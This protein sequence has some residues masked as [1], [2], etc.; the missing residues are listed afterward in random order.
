METE[1]HKHFI[2]HIDRL[3][4]LQTE[5]KSRVS[6]SQGIGKTS[7][8]MYYVLKCR[9]EKDTS[10]HYVDMNMIQDCDKDLSQ[11]SKYAKSFSKDD[12]L[13]IDHVTVQNEFCVDRLEEILV[14]LHKCKFQLILVEAGFTSSTAGRLLL[15]NRNL[16]LSE[17]EFS[18][19]WVESLK[20]V[21]E[22]KVIL[23]QGKEVYKLY[24]KDFI[25]TPKLL[26][27]VLL[28]M[29]GTT[30]KPEETITF[31]E[32]MLQEEIRN[33][34]IVREDNKM[35]KFILYTS[36][37]VHLI[38]NYGCCIFRIDQIGSVTVAIN[39]FEMQY[40]KVTKEDLATD[41]TFQMLG[42]TE[43]QSYVRLTFLIPRLAK[44]WQ[45]KLP[46]K[47]D[48]VIESSEHLKC[49]NS[50]RVLFQAGG[51]HK[52]IVNL[53]VRYQ[54]DVKLLINDGELMENKESNYQP[55]EAS[56]KILQKEPN[57]Q[58]ASDCEFLFPGLEVFANMKEVSK[59]V[60]HEKKIE[61]CAIML[62]ERMKSNP[63]LMYP[64]VSNVLGIDYFAYIPNYQGSG[65]PAAKAQ[66][67]TN[68]GTLLLVQVA[69]GASHTGE[70][71]GRSLNIVKEVIGECAR[72]RIAVLVAS[73]L[74]LYPLTRCQLENVSV[75]RMCTSCTLDMIKRTHG[76][77]YKFLQAN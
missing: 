53:I 76:T 37:L 63:V 21:E 45:E 8:L 40:L 6:E 23:Q 65:E 64:Q 29:S 56:T 74:R 28:K 30:L 19:L 27:F 5:L 73:E 75:L 31:Y 68:M 66:K 1:F 46:Y 18:T 62:K 43:G 33:F 24:S 3:K 25:M 36:T 72:V 71:L 42:L 9:K 54:M 39:I 47:F 41:A 60:G 61:Q 4:N 51:G 58:S 17:E 49:D 57:F 48:D 35:L 52:E 44:S 22:D 26:K 14:E 77:L 2:A 38:E 16:Q 55:A 15:F 70:T 59:Y 7:S 50:L 13:I 67:M 11:F 20:R 12:C 32:S 10:V 34:E 69:S